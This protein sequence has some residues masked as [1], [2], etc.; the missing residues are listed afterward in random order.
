MWLSGE[1][2]ID[3]YMTWGLILLLH[4][5]LTLNCRVLPQ[6][7]ACYGKTDALLPASEM[8]QTEMRDDVIKWKV[9]WWRQEC[10]CIT[11]WYSHSQEPAKVLHMEQYISVKMVLLKQQ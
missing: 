6:V 2:G 7:S 1:G 8:L 11:P 9:L 5:P 10:L 3:I 4:I